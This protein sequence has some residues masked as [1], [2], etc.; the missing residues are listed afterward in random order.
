VSIGPGSRLSH[1]QILDEISR[2]GMGVVYRA[3][4]LSL[5]REVALKVLPP[6]LVSNTE[7][8]QRF[9]QEAQ[10]A[11]ALEHPNIA[12]IYEIGEAD[13]VSFI[14][15]ELIRGEKLSASLSVSPLAAA[16]ALELAVEMAEA[17]ALAHDKGIVHRDLKPANVMVTQQGHAK[18]IDFGLAKLVAP[19]AGDAVSETKLGD[20]SPGTV[21]G[22]VSYMSPEQVRGGRVD[23]RTDIFSFGILL[24]EMLSGQPPFRGPSS[25]ET[26]N[27][28]LMATPPALPS[29]GGGVSPDAASEIQRIRDKCLAKAPDDRYQGMRDVVV[30]FRAARRRLESASFA[31]VPDSTRVR[32]F[33]WAAAVAVVAVIAVAFGANRWWSPPGT[34]PADT[35]PSLAVLYFENNTGNESLD[36]MRTGLADMLVTDLSQSPELEIVGTDRVQQ[37]LTELNRAEARTIGFDVVQELAR[38]AGVN[39]VLVGSYVKAGESIRINV[40]LQNPA[41]GRVL[42][43]ERVDAAGESSLFATVDD[44]TKRIKAKLEPL[45]RGRQ[46][47]GLF[48]TPVTVSTAMTAGVDRDLR[49]VTTSS[50][51][52]YRYYAEGINLHERQR[53]AES[54]PLFE[55]AL[56][57]DPNF[58]LAMAKL[59]VVHTNLNHPAEATDY[60]RRAFEHVDRVTARERYY[61]EGYHFARRQETLGRAIEAYEKGLSL[62]PDHASVRNNLAL[63][64]VQLERQDDALP[65]LEELRRRGMTFP[66]SYGILANIYGSRGEFETAVKVLQEY[67]QRHPDVAQAH[68]FLGFTLMM[69]GKLDDALAAYDRVDALDPGATIAA[70]GRFTVHV[71]RSQW[72]EARG[73]AEKLTPSQDPFR[74]LLGHS[75]L[76][77]L[78]LYRGV[79]PAA[80]AAFDRA[81]QAYAQPGANTAAARTRAAGVL[82]AVRN[83]AAALAEALKARSEGKGAGAEWA[84]IQAVA[85]AQMAT[86]RAAEANRTLDELRGLAAQLPS[87]RELR[88]V[89]HLAGEIAL[90]RGDHARAVQELLAAAKRLPRH[91][92]GGAGGGPGAG[93]AIGAAQIWFSLGSAY[94]AMGNA[95]GAEPWFRRLVE[96]TIERANAPIEYVRS[97]YLLATIHESRGEKEKARAGYQRF[98]EHWRDG[99]LDRDS[100]ASAERKLATR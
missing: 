28:I 20:T 99:D 7:R 76:A 80:L 30:D 56:A 100:V 88:R 92:T 64:Y 34:L 70:T 25:V 19:I 4:D 91:A 48:A 55:K 3:L 89:H 6:E 45:W 84:A 95:E 43:A 17:L 63:L 87:E 72:A 8:R 15:M 11:S 61:I 50:I 16:R 13:G 38:R 83:P 23:H 29:L 46:P 53:E 42:A 94:L 37:I 68:G 79:T 2:G 54:I 81:A 18:I 9:I 57:V 65:H 58:A 49:E 96:S 66:G 22:T 78:Q 73:V 59:A 75:Q 35:K 24:H 40:R 33:W 1:Y 86:G 47:S 67:L 77:T 26:L 12:V 74:R 93:A 44:L 60:A 52:A 41:D 39:T 62:F 82:I 14:A 71:L 90:E 21:V 98:L 97:L 51:E 85:L 27:S 36:W 69:W 5:N 31:A 32:R 10:A